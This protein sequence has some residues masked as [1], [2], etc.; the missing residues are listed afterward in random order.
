MEKNEEA[1]Q[2]PLI[3]ESVKDVEMVG[4]FLM[5]TGAV[6]G[7][8]ITNNKEGQE[9]EADKKDN[10][11]SAEA[12]FSTDDLPEDELPPIEEDGEE[13]YVEDDTQTEREYQELAMAL[14][15]GL[16]E[17]IDWFTLE[18]LYRKVRIPKSE[19]Q[20]LINGQ[21]TAPEL[22]QML[23]ESGVVDTIDSHNVR[24]KQMLETNPEDK[25]KLA[26]LL[27][28]VMDKRVGKIEITPEMQILLYT[29]KISHEK[30]RVVKDEIPS[31]NQQVK[32]EVELGVQRIINI[33]QN[34]SQEQDAK[35]Q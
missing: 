28:V 34:Q 16:I 29:F 9:E 4:D 14:G 6:E 19:Y 35:T 10:P 25:A 17:G 7:K 20:K 18:M 3:T 27:S 8:D 11:Q 15:T 33:Y 32:D 23:R 21:D 5:Q 1:I 31:L 2:S 30:Y 12:Q 22:R 24:L 13:G 26:K